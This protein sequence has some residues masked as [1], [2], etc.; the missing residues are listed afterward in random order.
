L[1]ADRKLV[2]LVGHMA[3]GKTTLGKALAKRLGW[4]FVDLDEMIEALERAT[5][6]EIFSRSG[7]AV[8]RNSET[9]ALAHVLT[10]Q[11]KSFVL[12]LGGGAFVRKE[13]QE[14]LNQAH[15]HCIF[16]TTTNDELWARAT[17]VGS[18]ERPMLRD[19]AAFDALLSTRLHDFR[20]AQ[21]EMSTSER[22]VEQSAAE[23]ENRL[24]SEGIA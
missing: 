24:R 2:C 14:L 16:L 8:F 1:K 23:I 3:A 17:A 11:K 9:A 10:T 12:A 7:Q 13:N 21:W 6:T 22:S 5:V 20:R 18:P 19:R 15:A 4:P